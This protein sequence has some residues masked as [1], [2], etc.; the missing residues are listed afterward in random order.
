VE[1]KA[2]IL[3]GKGDFDKV[4]PEHNSYLFSFIFQDPEKGGT[5][6]C[7]TTTMVLVGSRYR[8]QE[9]RLGKQ[10]ISMSVE[11]KRWSGNFRDLTKFNQALLGKWKW[12]LFYYQGELW[13]RVLDSKYGG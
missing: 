13:A 5:Q 9:D 1:T 2:T 6:A 3:C 11:R 4:S 10:W 12:N 7:E 8:T